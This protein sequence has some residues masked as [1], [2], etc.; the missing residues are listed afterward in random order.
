[1]VHGSLFMVHL[2]GSARA[3]DTTT[4]CYT[5]DVCQR[6]RR[7][8]RGRGGE[9]GTVGRGGGWGGRGRHARLSKKADCMVEIAMHWLVLFDLI[10]SIESF[11][12]CLY[13]SFYYE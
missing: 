5:A 11:R 10:D 12:V 8:R 13:Y 4:G 6:A 7:A 3:V 2:P 9:T 1:M